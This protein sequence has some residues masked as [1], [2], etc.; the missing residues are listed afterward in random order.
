M[1]IKLPH[2]YFHIFHS[3]HYKV[4]LLVS[5]NDKVTHMHCL[6]HHTNVV[7]GLRDVLFVKTK[8]RVS[9]TFGSKDMVRKK[10]ADL[11]ERMIFS[12]MLRCKESSRKE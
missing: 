1:Q 4:L 10:G 5:N 6:P 11:R 12:S 2:R 9:S 3:C 7:F 8:V